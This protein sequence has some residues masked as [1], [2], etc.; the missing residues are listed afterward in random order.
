M[1]GRNKTRRTW[2]RE[3]QDLVVV[4]DGKVS[5]AERGGGKQEPL[6]AERSKKKG[7]KGA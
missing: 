4:G 1:Q 6:G 5:G 2:W 3:R 7:G